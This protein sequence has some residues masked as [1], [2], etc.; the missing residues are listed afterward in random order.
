[1]IVQGGVRGREQPIWTGNAWYMALHAYQ[2][3]A[4]AAGNEISK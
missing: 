2:D 4:A 1:M 3:Q